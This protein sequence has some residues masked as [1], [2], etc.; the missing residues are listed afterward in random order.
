MGTLD[1]ITAPAKIACQEM[2]LTTST[3]TDDS[4]RGKIVSMVVNENSPKDD[5]AIGDSS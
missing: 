1:T 3:S 5:S 4:Q 2:V